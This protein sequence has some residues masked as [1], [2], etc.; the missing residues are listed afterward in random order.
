ME[1][2]GMRKLNMGDIRDVTSQHRKVCRNRTVGMFSLM[3]Y[4]PAAG[5]AESFFCYF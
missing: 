5:L 3:C 1:G 4:H 2:A